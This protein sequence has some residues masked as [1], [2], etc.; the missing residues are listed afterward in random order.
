M[1]YDQNTPTSE[2]AYEVGDEL[3]TREQYEAQR[4]EQLNTLHAI[5]SG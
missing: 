4:K 5:F 3:L 1:N 2:Q